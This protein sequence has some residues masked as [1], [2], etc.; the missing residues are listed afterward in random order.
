[1]GP[2]KTANRKGRAN[3]KEESYLSTS[4]I[5]AMEVVQVAKRCVAPDRPQVRFA[6]AEGPFGHSLAP[7]RA[8][9]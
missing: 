9:L 7:P 1:M 5:A 6:N 3:N 2:D 4:A 8:I